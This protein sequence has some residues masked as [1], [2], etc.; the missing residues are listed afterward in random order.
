[1]RL[2]RPEP[3]CR[4]VVSSQHQD[5]GTSE[6]GRWGGSRHDRL[7]HIRDST[8]ARACIKAIGIP[9]IGADHFALSVGGQG[10]AA[11]EKKRPSLVDRG[12]G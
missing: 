3:R 12:D 11:H 9:Q 8:P 1:M 6:R 5:F 4:S 7:G 10:D 2:E